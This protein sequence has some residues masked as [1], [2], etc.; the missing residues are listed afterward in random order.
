MAQAL[1][2][3]YP[4]SCDVRVSGGGSDAY[5]RVT[6]VMWTSDEQDPPEAEQLGDRRA[7]VAYSP[8]VAELVYFL[9]GRAAEFQ[10]SRHMWRFGNAPVEIYETYVRLA[11]AAMRIDPFYPQDLPCGMCI[12]KLV[13]TRRQAETPAVLAAKVALGAAL[14]RNVREGDCDECPDAAALDAGTAAARQRRRAR[15][16]GVFATYQLRLSDADIDELL[17]FEY[18]GEPPRQRQAQD[19]VAPSA[20]IALV[21]A[22]VAPSVAVARMAQGRAAAA[23]ARDA[24]AAERAAAA[25]SDK[26]AQNGVGG[27]P[28]TWWKN[29]EAFKTPAGKND[30]NCLLNELIERYCILPPGK[31]KLSEKMLRRRF[32]CDAAGVADTSIARLEAFAREYTIPMR[33]YN[34][35]SPAPIITTIGGKS[36]RVGLALICWCEHAWVFTG[37]NVAQ[38]VPELITPGVYPGIMT[39]PVNSTRASL[40]ESSAEIYRRILR[41]LRPNFQYAAESRVVAK[42]PYS[43]ICDARPGATYISID[44]VKCYHSALYA[45]PDT[46]RI[47]VFTAC[48]TWL[49][50]DSS[51]DIVPQAYYLVGSDEHRRW[52]R[53]PRGLLNV[54][55]NNM[56]TGYELLWYVSRGYIQK[57]AVEWV[58]LPHYDLPAADFRRKLEELAKDTPDALRQDFALF[59]GLLGISQ[60]W[61]QL[62]MLTVC[63]QDA[64]LLQ[65]TLSD[66]AYT[67][68]EVPEGY[69]LPPATDKMVKINRGRDSFLY[70]NN[71]H[72]Y[73]YV[74]ACANVAVAEAAEALAPLVGWPLRV[75]VDGFT[76]ERPTQREYPQFVAAVK[77]L[78]HAFRIEAVAKPPDGIH[79][80]GCYIDGAELSHAVRDEIAAWWNKHHTG[81][82][83]PPGTGKTTIV[84][85][86]HYGEFKHA[87]ALTNMCARQLTTPGTPGVDGAS[88]VETV[89]G[90]TIHS[91]LQLFCPDEL[92]NVCNKLAGERIWID[93]FS[94][95]NAW[96]WSVLFVVGLETPIIFTGDPRQCSP[97]GRTAAGGIGGDPLPWDGALLTKVVGASTKLVRDYRNDAP[98]IELRE[99]IDTGEKP[100]SYVYQL[101][102]RR[103]TLDWR[104]HSQIE[105]LRSVDY[106]LVWGHAYRMEL[107]A[108]IL[109]ARGLTWSAR[110]V[111]QKI[112]I[113]AEAFAERRFPPA[114]K[115]GKGYTY[116][117]SAGIKLIA[118]VNQKTH[119]I[120]KG[121]FYQLCEAI[122]H[123]TANARLMEIKA[124]TSLPVGE[125]ITIPNGLLINFAIG[126][127]ITAPSSQGMTIENRCVIHQMASWLM[128]DGEHR[129]I[130]YTAVTRMRTL[131]SIILVPGKM[132][133]IGPAPP[134]QQ[135]A[136]NLFDDE[137]ADLGKDLVRRK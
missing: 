124:G 111:E 3:A 59:N 10:A 103:P 89:E 99:A 122:E 56:L 74:I 82:T 60:T 13:N 32:P 47:G 67:E 22:A 81:Y 90:K 5:G 34:A 18:V 110:P 37:G 70:L 121:T 84:K 64:A 62:T 101:M 129:E 8:A 21:A 38:S 86:E 40:E 113:G 2:H 91:R 80:H 28:R 15:R 55:I 93:E 109:A 6:F 115:R 105:L 112:P 130:A 12:P 27:A 136:F 26:R 29:Y 118:R 131:D 107:N 137:C 58:K 39:P 135:E 120:L 134:D 61:S 33:V 45:A 133:N 53:D 65:A 97:I 9:R 54:R 63:E 16:D 104:T 11:S 94:M 126:Y 95:V 73:S 88:A 44:M 123:D 92:W 132:S 49:R 42:S 96:I 75:R 79:S 100:L 76:Y 77:G 31:Q 116:K 17:G 87:I 114:N 1:V 43:S 66:A 98:L 69:E 25:A 119:G 20:G 71:R 72:L 106:H 19:N 51:A 48:D 41:E 57:A 36:P 4:L 78:R 52:N 7:A 125:A 83:G 102:K 127:A 128:N 108:A 117:A 24:A 14:E 30:P 68:A 35:I 50:Y 85:R 23:A 46:D